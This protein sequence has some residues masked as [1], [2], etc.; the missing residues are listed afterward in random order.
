MDNIN[1]SRECISA[2]IKGILQNKGYHE[3]K[4]TAVNNIID[5]I[6]NQFLK[7]LNARKDTDKN[8]NFECYH[9]DVKFT[10]IL[11]NDEIKMVLDETN[12]CNDLKY[13]ILN[14][15]YYI[16]LKSVLKNY[17]VKFYFYAADYKKDNDNNIISFL[18][19]FKFIPSLINGAL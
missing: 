15:E 3:I 9:Y 8:F 11:S 1:I 2:K 6:F 7:F 12:I 4:L 16:N 19:Y 14:N 18:L 10:Y 5:N 17:G 13:D